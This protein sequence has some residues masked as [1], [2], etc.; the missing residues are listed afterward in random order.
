MIVNEDDPICCGVYK[1]SKKSIAKYIKGNS[2]KALKK[3]Q[4]SKRN[5]WLVKG[6]ESSNAILVREE[7]KEIDFDGVDDART[8]MFGTRVVDLLKVVSKAKLKKGEVI[9]FALDH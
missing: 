2:E 1:I 5:Y 6:Y 7:P 3:Y 4:E 9:V 8:F